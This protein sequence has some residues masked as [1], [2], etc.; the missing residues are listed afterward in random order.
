MATR[1]GYYNVYGQRTPDQIK[2]EVDGV[3]VWV[4]SSCV[5]DVRLGPPPWWANQ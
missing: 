2:V 1:E 4:N 5:K 3:G